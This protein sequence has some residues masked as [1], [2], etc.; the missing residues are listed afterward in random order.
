MV[1]P[2]ILMQADTPTTSNIFDRAGDRLEIW[3]NRNTDEEN[4]LEETIYYIRKLL[5]LHE[6]ERTVKIRIQKPFEFLNV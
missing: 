5:Y 3:K 6:N 4:G 1:K 2:F